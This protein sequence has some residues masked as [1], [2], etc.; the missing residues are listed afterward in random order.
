MKA[1]KTFQIKMVL[2]ALFTLF[3]VNIFAQHT[4]S[5]TVFDD[6]GESAIGVTIREKGTNN[7]V[8]TDINGKFT[9]TVSNQNAVLQVSSIGF[10]QQEIKIA[11]RKALT[12]RLVEDRK[13]LSETVV[14]GYGTMKKRLP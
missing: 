8:A 14:V 10:T 13:L 7:G 4:V 3:S 11:G 1:K 6:L 12:I 9:I 2:I 5:G